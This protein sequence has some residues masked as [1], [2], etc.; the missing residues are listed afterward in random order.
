MQSWGLNVVRP[1]LL[2]PTLIG[3]DVEGEEEVRI[4][5]AKRPGHVAHIDFTVVPTTG[6]ST[7]WFPFSLPQI[8]PFAHWVA[9]VEDHFSRQCLGFAVFA[10][11]PTTKETT[12]FLDR[13][14]QNRGKPDHLISD[15]GPQFRDEYMEWCQGQKIQFRRG[16][17]GEH[18]SISVVERCIKT[19]K[20]ECIPHSGV[21]CSID[22]FREELELYFIWYNEYRAHEYLGGRTPNE[23]FDQVKVPACEKPRIELRDRWPEDSDCAKP[24]VPIAGVPGATPILVIGFLEGRKHLPIINFIDPE[25]T[26]DAA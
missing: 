22:R 18:G 9:I 26:A 4:V 20:N 8:H 5:T 13:I 7:P 12:D 23:V 17:V 14:F 6:L 15:K 3:Q 2:P 11:E 10:K 24:S 19:M 1:G 16:K 21:S 25:S